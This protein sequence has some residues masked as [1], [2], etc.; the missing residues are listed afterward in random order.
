MNVVRAQREPAR[1]YAKRLKE[2]IEELNVEIREALEKDLPDILSLCSQLDN[3]QILDMDKAKG[4]YNRINLYPNYKIYFAMAGESV[5]GMF[6]LLV[7]ENLGHLGASSGVIEDVVVDTSWRRKGIGRQMLRFA[8]ERCKEANCYK[9]TLSSNIK[10]KDAH[11]FYE[12]LGFDIHG[13]SFK[14]EIN[15]I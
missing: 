4:I 15:N 7:M 2:V 3:G 5:V 1:R 9:L 10:R 8:I 11:S 13:Y 6:A 14:I 12:S